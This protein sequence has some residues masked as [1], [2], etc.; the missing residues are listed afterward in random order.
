MC[1]ALPFCSL[2]KVNFR[3]SILDMLLKS[4]LKGKEFNTNCAHYR[5][6]RF[7]DVARHG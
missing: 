5:T 3:R 7:E 6:G 4:S 2:V 1:K